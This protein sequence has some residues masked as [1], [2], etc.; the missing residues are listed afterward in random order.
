M[1]P[2]QL[3]L[4]IIIGGGIGLFFGGFWNGISAMVLIWIAM[5]FE[6]FIRTYEKKNFES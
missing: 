6:Y 4:Y 3:M 5:R 2:K 1:I